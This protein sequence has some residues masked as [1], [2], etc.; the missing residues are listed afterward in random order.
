MTSRS[1]DYQI[2]HTDADYHITSYDR[3]ID[4]TVQYLLG[5]YDD[6]PSMMTALMTIIHTY[7]KYTHYI[8]TYIH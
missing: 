2:D 5:Q 4:K 3:E 1:D 8:H 6:Q 7:I